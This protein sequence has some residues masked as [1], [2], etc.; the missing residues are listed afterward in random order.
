LA[1]FIYDDPIKY[2]VA[3][4][5]NSV[6]IDAILAK[7]D[8]CHMTVTHDMIISAFDGSLKKKLKTI[9]LLD[10]SIVMIQSMSGEEVWST[11]Y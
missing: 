8:D 11:R 6:R 9:N 5:I 3:S 10:V 7:T 4:A 1:K 2:V